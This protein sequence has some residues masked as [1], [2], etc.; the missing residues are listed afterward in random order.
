MLVVTAR[1]KVN[2]D[3]L[4]Q[5]LCVCVLLAEITHSSMVK[6]TGNFLTTLTTT[7][8]RCFTDVTDRR[9]GLV[10]KVR[11]QQSAISLMLLQASH[12]AHS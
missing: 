11:G 6:A 2:E 8:C 3:R 7:V 5:E 10:I 12:T 9:Q 4:N 1:F